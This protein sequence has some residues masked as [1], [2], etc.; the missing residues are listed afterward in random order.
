[1]TE[2]LQTFR[3]AETARSLA[4]RI[5]KQYPKTSDSLRWLDKNQHDF[6]ERII[7][8]ADVL[9]KINTLLVNPIQ[10]KLAY[11][12]EIE[13]L[14]KRIGS[15]QIPTLP[16]AE[17]ESRTLSP[18]H[19]PALKAFFQGR[20]EFSWADDDYDQTLP[21]K[22]AMG[23]FLEGYGRYIGLRMT[24]TIEKSREI[25]HSFVEAFEAVLL[26]EHPQSSLLSD[27]KGWM[28]SEDHKFSEPIQ[29]VLN[30][31]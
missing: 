1:M 7:F 21:A 31:V 20:R 4:V 8:F 29:K 12:T 6:K 10:E 22:S 9:E 13:S 17:R 23:I 25:Q 11:I 27:V 24:N 5:F 30:T 18:H 14:K 3:S 26:I 15:N 16:D 2:Y 28:K 19:S